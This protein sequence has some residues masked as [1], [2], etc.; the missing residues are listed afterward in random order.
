MIA[1]IQNWIDKQAKPIGSGTYWFKTLD[2]SEGQPCLRTYALHVLKNKPYQIKEVVREYLNGDICVHGDLYF[3]GAA[4]YRVMWEPR[5]HWS[6]Y[7]PEECDD[8]WYLVDLKTAPGMECISLY[9][10]ADVNR[11]FKKYIPYFQMNDHLNV[12]VYAQRYKEFASAEQLSK[13]GFE[14]LVMDKRVLKLN[15]SSKKKLIHWLIE[16]GDC[17]KNHKPVYNDISKAVKLG[18]TMEKFYYESAIDVYEKQFK[19]RQLERT[20]EECEQVYKYLNNPKKPQKIGLHNYLDYLEMMK[21]AGYDMNE[22]S[23]LYPLDC[24]RAHDNIVAQKKKKESEEINQKLVQI[25]TALKKYE[26]SCKDLKLVIPTCQK[27][28]VSWGKK[29]NICVGTYGYDKKMIEGKCIILMV[30]LNDQPL[31]CCELTKKDRGNS[32]KIEQLRG[33]HNG[34]SP[35]HSDCE[36][37]VNQFIRNVG[38]NW[39]VTA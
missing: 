16:N 18:W 31:E 15:K 9:T 33:K 12:M 3:C 27:D 11:I 21:E 22:K 4:G 28:F 23:V 39:Q 34:E 10:N 35:R 19:D 29:L 2:D 17:V 24:A 8:R 5:K 7:M 13:A 26:I 38:K 32:L 36:K 20:R 25:S 6:Y 30:Y 1:Q 37:L 14:Y